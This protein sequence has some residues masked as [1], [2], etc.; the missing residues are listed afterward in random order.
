[1]LEYIEQHVNG[2]QEIMHLRT[3]ESYYFTFQKHIKGIYNIKG[4]GLQAIVHVDT[5]FSRS[6]LKRLMWHVHD[7]FIFLI[8][9]IMSASFGL[10]LSLSL[11]LTQSFVLLSLYVML[12]HVILQCNMD[13]MHHSL[14]YRLKLQDSSENGMRLQ[15]SYENVDLITTP[16]Y[17]E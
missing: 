15:Y 1:M 2:I 7:N 6:S 17:T 11:S 9:L 12:C 16:C 4:F 3:C 8:S 10:S 14:F 13:I 5:T